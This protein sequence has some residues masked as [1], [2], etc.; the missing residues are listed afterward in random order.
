MPALSM[1]TMAWIVG[2]C[3]AAYLGCI[4][5]AIM[6]PQKQPDPQRGMAVGCLMIAAIPGVVLALLLVIGVIGGYEGLVRV[7]FYITAVPMAYL[8]VLLIAQP[9]IKRRQNRG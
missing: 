8:L 1:A 7:L 2:G 6:A 4:V 9:I 3:L 5:Y